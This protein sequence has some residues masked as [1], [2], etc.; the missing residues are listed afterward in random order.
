MI[1]DMISEMGMIRPRC[2]VFGGLSF[3]DRP[4]GRPSALLKMRARHMIGMRTVMIEM[5][6]GMSSVEPEFASAKNPIV[7]RNTVAIIKVAFDK[8]FVAGCLRA[9][10]MLD[11]ALR[12]ANM[13]SII[14]SRY[15]V[16]SRYPKNR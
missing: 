16:P 7:R 12:A 10:R 14:S 13:A 8:I 15:S 3:L 6:E 5:I 1:T 2:H 11:E 9:R 4:A